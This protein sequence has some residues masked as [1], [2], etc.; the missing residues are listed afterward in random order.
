GVR[1]L[2]DPRRFRILF[3]RKWSGGIAA[4]CK[5]RQHFQAVGRKRHAECPPATHE[6]F[7]NLPAM[8]LRHDRFIASGAEFGLAV[9]CSWRQ[10]EEGAKTLS[11]LVV[12]QFHDESAVGELRLK[13]EAIIGATGAIER[14]DDRLPVGAIRVDAPDA[15]GDA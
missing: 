13:V 4:V 2:P 9:R 7:W 10:L 3:I 14:A 1:Q 15:P 5:A 12:V 6:E 11:V 8:L